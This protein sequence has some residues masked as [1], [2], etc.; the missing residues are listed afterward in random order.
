MLVAKKPL[1]VLALIKRIKRSQVLLNGICLNFG[2][3]IYVGFMDAN[4]VLFHSEISRKTTFAGHLIAS[5]EVIR[6][7]NTCLV[8]QS[9]II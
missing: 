3:I 1:W 2:M 4:K 8:L 7:I 9:E 6:K 5:V